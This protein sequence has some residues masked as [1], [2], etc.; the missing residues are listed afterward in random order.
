VRTAPARKADSISSLGTRSP[1]RS[2]FQ[3]YKQPG[4]TPG[5]GSRWWS[6]WG[7][8][9]ERFGTILEEWILPLASSISTEVISVC[10]QV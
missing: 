1:R 5:S 10:L 7:R 9:A 8:Y 3:A 2:H 4:S 6:F